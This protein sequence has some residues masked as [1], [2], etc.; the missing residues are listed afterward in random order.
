MTPDSWPMP[1]SRNRD[2]E[3]PSRKRHDARSTRKSCAL[4]RLGTALVASARDR[5]VS[6]CGVVQ[7]WFWPI[8]GCRGVKS[9]AGTGRRRELGLLAQPPTPREPERR[10]C[11]RSP[12]PVSLSV[13]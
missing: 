4:W 8:S 5:T 10:K 9:P 2:Y 6:G 13:C 1:P 12:T 11:K 3:G 7:T